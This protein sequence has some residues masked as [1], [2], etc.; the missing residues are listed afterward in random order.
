MFLSE[1]EDLEATDNIF[2]FLHAIKT[3]S[4]QLHSL[5]DDYLIL[6]HRDL[7]DVADQLVSSFA[8]LDVYD[9]EETI[10][11]IKSKIISPESEDPENFLYEDLE[12]L[13]DLAEE[14][15]ELSLF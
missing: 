2:Y 1:V 6:T 12:T 11:N 13:M 10:L 5:P 3:V 14:A 15:I 8:D 7:M 4:A 9:I